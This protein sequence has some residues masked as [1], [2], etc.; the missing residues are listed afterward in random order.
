MVQDKHLAEQL[1]LILSDNPGFERNSML[2]QCG[3]FW[4]NMQTCFFQRQL[5]QGLC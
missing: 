5:G 3:A 1:D 2:V 4:I